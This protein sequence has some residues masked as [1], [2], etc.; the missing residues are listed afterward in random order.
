MNYGAV[1]QLDRRDRHVGRSYLR[2]AEAS[3]QHRVAYAV[4]EALRLADLP[5]EEEGRIHCFRR[6]SLSGIPANTNRRVWIERLQ[7]VLGV[8]AAQALHGTDPR[9]RSANA[10]YFHN[11]EEALETLLRRAVHASSGAASQRPEWFASSFLGM[12]PQT[13]YSLQ[14][15][16]ILERLRQPP[17]SLG[18]AAG[19]LFAVLSSVDPTVLLSAVRSDIVRDWLRELEGQKSVSAETAPIQVT[20]QIRT[21]LQRTVLQFGWRDPHTI[22]LATLAVI[23]L[24][25]GSLSAGTAVKLARSTLRL[26]E[27]EQPHTPRDRDAALVPGAASRPL[28]FSD[29]GNYQDDDAEGAITPAVADRNRLADNA[30]PG[31][32]SLTADMNTIDREVREA[33][34]HAAGSDEGLAVITP[35]LGE[36]TQAAGLYFFLHVLRRLGIEAALETCPA[37]AEASFAA[38]IL[39]QLATHAETT[40]SDPILL[41]L[42]TDHSEFSLSVEELGTISLRPKAWPEGF[43]SP[44][45][46]G[47]TSDY[48]LRLWL[49]AVKRWCWR[50][51]RIKVGEIVNRKGRVWLTR[52]DLD[53]TLPLADADIR[54]RRIGL[55]ID[56]G[57]VPWLGEFGRVV[58]FHYSDRNP[59]SPGC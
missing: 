53:V 48:F 50:S 46:A 28:V 20:S 27:E 1:V 39:K 51:A 12:A 18:V 40:Q 7:Q 59:E 31:E 3:S 24:S 15:P 55:D 26:L 6:I 56:P 17:L 4:E 49:V 52:T 44:A 13:S 10:V 23:R 42:Q 47:F 5:G 25:P 38:H 54:I 16:A 34:P 9:A 19:I 58:R 29:A 11:R 45:S 8:A 57:W 35:L 32:L 41:C 22:W 2:I 43:S 37:L 33:V 14:I 30:A 21:M 36:P